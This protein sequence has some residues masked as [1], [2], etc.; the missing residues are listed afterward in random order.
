MPPARPHHQGRELLAQRVALA[1]GAHV[2]QRAAHRVHAVGLAADDVDPR[3]RK[4]VLEVPHEHPRARVQRVDH[5]LPLHRAG[6]LHPAVGEIGR[7]G[8]HAPFGGADV[9]GLLQKIGQAAGTEPALDFEAAG[10]QLLAP[11]S[12]PA[13]QLLHELDGVGCED[14]VLAW[15]VRSTDLEGCGHSAGPQREVGS[16][17]S[18]AGSTRRRQGTAG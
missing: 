11:G 13:N 16:G 6:D 3:R 4:C 18:V 12:E 15:N 1:L 17:R 14:P 7:R 5:H 2:L 9:G 8:R 10:Q